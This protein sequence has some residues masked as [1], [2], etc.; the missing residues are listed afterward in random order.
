MNQLIQLLIK[1]K[2]TS[3]PEKIQLDVT[4][5]ITHPK[6]NTT[7]KD[8]LFRSR[9]NWLVLTKLNCN[10]LNWLDYLVSFYIAMLAN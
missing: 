8:Q 1:V 3:T 4:V 7:G 5:N 6:I 2:P 10:N 9:K